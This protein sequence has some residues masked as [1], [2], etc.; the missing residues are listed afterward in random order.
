MFRELF[1]RMQYE[2]S[3]LMFGDKYRTLDTVVMD[4][5][6]NAIVTTN[7]EM[8][9]SAVLNN[10]R[11]TVRDIFEK[12]DMQANLMD[13]KNLHV[14]RLFG[15]SKPAENV[16]ELDAEDITDKAVSML[17]RVAEIIK[18][19]GIILIEDFEEPLFSHK[20]LRKAF[21][22]LFENQ[23]QVYIFNCKE[24]DKYLSYLESKGI[25]VLTEKSVNAFFEEYL[26]EDSDFNQDQTE[27]S[28][29]FYIEAGKKA[30]PTI[31]EKKQLI[32]TDSFATLL[33]IELLN[34]IKIPSNMYK[35]YFYTFLKNSVREPQWFGYTYGFNLHR[36]F[37]DR[38]Y[39]KVKKGL[40][41]VGKPNNR[42][43][44]VVGQTGTGKSIS[45]A[46]LSY[47]IFN[48][49]NYPVIYINDSD[50]NFYSS[51]EYKQK[52]I[53]KKGSPAFSALDA[54]LEKLENLGA[55]ATLLVWDTSSY[56]SGREKC[57]RLYQELLARGRKVYLVSSAYEINDNYALLDSDD[58][59]VEDSVMNRKFVECRAVNEVSSETDQ[60][61]NILLNK[62][63]MDE[64]EVDRIISSYAGNNSNYLSMFYRAFEMLRGDLSQGVYR[65]ASAN[66]NDLDQL[67][68]DE[69]AT[70]SSSNNAFSLAL[71][72]IETELI[73]AGLVTD[74]EAVNDTEKETI[75]VAKDDFIKCIAVCA[76]FKIKMPYDFALRILG[77]YNGK[78][79][80]TLMKST[81]FV[82][83]QDYYENY[84]ISLRTPLEAQ[85]YISAKN[86]MPL[87]EVDCIVKML[88]VMNAS[89]WY[90][91]QHEVRFCEKII[92]I[93]GPNNP[94][95][96]IR[97]KYKNGYA[98]II[99]ALERLRTQ[100]NIWEPRLI[101]QEIT[102][103][104]EHYG[105]DDALD[106]HERIRILE[107]A[108]G[109]AD[110]VLNTIENTGIPVG[111]R[112]AIVVESANSK[113]LLCQLKETN[114][115]LL[116]RELRRD[117]RD[118]IRYDSMNYY[119]YVTLLKGSIT[120]Y[121]NENDPVRKIELLKSMCSIADE[122]EFE[123]PDVATSEYFQRQ[124]AIIYSYLNE[125]EVLDRYV[126]ELVSNGS[127]AGLY[128]IARKTLSENNVD[129]KEPISNSI[130]SSACEEVYGM[131]KNERYKAVLEDSEACQY[132][133]L[134]IV[135]LMNNKNPIISQGECWL[136]QMNDDTWRELLGI[137]NN[138][139]RRFCSESD[140]VYRMAKNI[141]YIKALCLG[142]LGLYS[143]SMATLREIEE[144]SSL[145]IKRVYTKHMLCDKNGVPL[146]FTGRLG[147]YDEVQRSGDI[148]IEEFGK[149]PIYYFGP[150][151]K[152]TN[153]TEG[154]V[155]DDIE[156]GYSNIAPKAFRD[157]EIKE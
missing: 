32:E 138:Y 97:R 35:E 8:K 119:A 79:I 36:D 14:I 152:T 63:R 118:V 122:L 135:W 155:F 38:L 140:N 84:E 1:T 57:F 67:L 130:Q 56:S 58:E 113:L 44:L 2:P 40:E 77:T 153:F 5:G 11:R 124:V 129:F 131:F 13:R 31:I 10:E 128:V 52:G 90:G 24:K 75:E 59:Y 94:N 72:K 62:C 112:N 142:Q 66:L 23:K 151:L 45:L 50:V 117:L 42:P 134:N 156:I 46:A 20:E 6:W 64:Q 102:Y 121:R 4:Y 68:V 83:T 48:E 82:I 28:I 34:D 39:R 19:N 147:K 106:I 146:K 33:N 9:L 115:V 132:M 136:T 116:F 88:D 22:E 108:I 49:K 85:M 141:R 91:Q 15:E 98:S 29:S 25:A 143:E 81:F 21:I 111:T 104:R 54:L 157:I 133:Y 120:E 144:D 150:R 137:C 70:N 101:T 43:T 26:P 61:R 69:S 139:I 125:S 149:N 74:L 47:K 53:N 93:I 87:D 7:C 80:Q 99:D 100:K 105:R 126:S 95:Q 3:V 16:D 148:Y 103:L 110:D 51:V 65:E 27:R 55:K 73:S 60:L 17:S 154:T 109:V 92:R 114:D 76:Q 18:R 107:K 96:E 71:K 37:E 12:K 145:G 127:A 86:M 123:N 30:I 41:N 78:I 89:S